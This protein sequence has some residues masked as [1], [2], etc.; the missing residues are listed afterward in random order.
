MQTDKARRGTVPTTVM[1]VR[2]EGFMA[3]YRG[4]SAS[5]LRQITYSTVRFGAY[6]V[7]KV[8]AGETEKSKEEEEEEEDGGSPFPPIEDYES[9]LVFFFIITPTV[10]SSP[11]FPQQDRRGHALWRYW[12]PLR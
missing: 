5:L 4:L 3:L 11:L 12:W 2:N 6:D 7:F 10:P 9:G 1:I 8:W